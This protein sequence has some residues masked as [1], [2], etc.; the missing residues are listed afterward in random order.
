[1]SDEMAVIVDAVKRIATVAKRKNFANIPGELL[2]YY[3]PYP[4]AKN[5]TPSDLIDLTVDQSEVIEDY[6]RD[7]Q[8]RLTMKQIEE[9]VK[10]FV[11]Q[12]PKEFFSLYRIGD[13]CLPIGTSEGKDWDSIFNYFFF[14]SYRSQF[15]TLSNMINAYCS[16][17]VDRNPSLLPICTYQEEIVLC[18]LGS[19]TQSETSPVLITYDHDLYRD[20][21]DMEV[22]W[23]SLSNM[24]LAYAESYETSSVNR[25]EIYHKYGSGSDWGLSNFLLV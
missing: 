12:L 13:G 19:E 17:L 23:P 20:P 24:M 7:Y 6:I 4:A 3:D 5:I 14:I 11:F 15:L 8:P 25:K 2:S 9:M 22:M 16:L 10:P 1:M 21:S 18:I